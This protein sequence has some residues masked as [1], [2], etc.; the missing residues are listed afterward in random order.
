MSLLAG[1][2]FF[3][4]PTSQIEAYTTLPQF[5]APFLPALFVVLC[6]MV[7]EWVCFWLHKTTRPNWWLPMA[8]AAMT[9]FVIIWDSWCSNTPIAFLVDSPDAEGLQIRLQIIAYGI[10]AVGAP[11][12]MIYL[13]VRQAIEE[14]ALSGFPVLLLRLL[15]APAAL[16]L[17]FVRVQVALEIFSGVRFRVFS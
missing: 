17:L 6:V 16:V 8:L 13:G 4:T 7:I 10:L 12:W 5:I 1:V 2:P 11:L 9:V 3:E 14:H 15:P